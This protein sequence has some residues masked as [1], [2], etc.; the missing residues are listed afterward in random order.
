MY[1][2]HELS[3]GM[4]VIQKRHA[5][6][7]IREGDEVYLQGDEASEFLRQMNRAK[8]KELSKR[9]NP[10]NIPIRQYIMA[11]YFIRGYS[12]QEDRQ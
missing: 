9:C 10:N 4:I 12:C 3:M 7:F 2:Y 8:Q 1:E 5:T 11:D 6:G